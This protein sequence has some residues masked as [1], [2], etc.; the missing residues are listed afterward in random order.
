MENKEKLTLEEQLIQI[1]QEGLAW[2]KEGYLQDSSL[3]RI[4]VNHLYG[5]SC[6]LIQLLDVINTAN[7]ELAKKYV[8]GLIKNTP[9]K[10]FNLDLVEITGGVFLMGSP[11]EEEGCYS[12]EKPQ[13]EVT[14]KPFL[15]GKYPV[16]QAQWKAVAALTKVD[17]D[18]EADPFRFKG[19]SLPVENVSWNEAVE[20]CKRLSVHSGREYR[21][22]SEAEWEYACRAGTTTPFHFGETLTSELANYR[23]TDTYGSGPK[24]E[25]RKKTTEVGSFPANVFG[26]YDMHGNVYEWCQD[27]WHVNYAAAPPD[28]SAWVEGGNSGRRVLRGGSWYDNPSNCRSAYRDGYTPDYRDNIFGFRVCCPI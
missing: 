28:G 3:T 12:E 25:Y 19:D 4:M 6:S 7:K 18:L 26:L 14:I 27:H 23:A 21:L 15:M 1:H 9:F 17:R 8:K 24:G 11:E 22:P 5:E 2:E 13:H 10:E 20:F 16:T